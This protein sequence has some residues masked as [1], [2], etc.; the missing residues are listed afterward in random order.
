MTEPPFYSPNYRAPTQKLAK[1]RE[2]AWEFQQDQTTWRAELLFHGESWG[3]EAQIAR[4]G[5]LVI[6]RRFDTKALAMQWV[7]LERKH[8]E[9]GGGDAVGC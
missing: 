7:N 6:G 4:D 5:D 8:L 9:K 3:W 1:P 2:L